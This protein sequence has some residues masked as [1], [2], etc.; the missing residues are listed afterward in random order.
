MQQSPSIN[1]LR[2]YV[3]TMLSADMTSYEVIEALKKRGVSEEDAAKL[4]QECDE[5][6]N[7]EMRR[8]GN[9]KILIGGLVLL[10]G[11][12]VT[13]ATTKNGGGIIAYGAIIYGLID[14]VW[15]FKI[16]SDYA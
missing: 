13:I 10:I 11:L 3:M 14:L 9:R 6:F 2:A 1:E 16:R 4:Y 5:H 12:V 15:G 7:Q 8:K